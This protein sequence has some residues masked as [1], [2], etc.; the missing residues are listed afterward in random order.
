MGPILLCSALALAVFVRK[1]LQIHRARLHSI[2]WLPEALASVQIGAYEEAARRCDVEFHPAARVVSA[3]VRTL[4][5]RP[6]RAEAEGKRV[7]SLELQDLERHLG[8]L[9]FVAQGAPLLGLLG[10]VLG[11]VDLFAGLGGSG[12]GAAGA[13]GAP[14][15]A[16]DA[17]LLSSGIWKALLTTAAGLSVAVPTLAAHTWTTSRTDRVRLQMADAIEQL[18][19]VATPLHTSQTPRA[20]REPLTLVAR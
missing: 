9:S 1:T 14:V 2:D 16:V 10:T 6:D 20:S 18:L 11:M 4:S 19:T 8:L 12:L 13:G 17:E 5:T 7:G 3:T 15:G